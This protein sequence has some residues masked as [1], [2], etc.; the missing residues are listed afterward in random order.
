M[1]SFSSHFLIELRRYFE[2]WRQHNESVSF[3]V[4]NEQN[5][6]RSQNRIS[7]ESATRKAKVQFG[8]RTDP[9]T[10]RGKICMFELSANLIVLFDPIKFPRRSSSIGQT[11][12]FRVL[13]FAQK[14]NSVS[15]DRTMKQSG[16]AKKLSK[17]QTKDSNSTLNSEKFGGIRVEQ[18]TRR[19]LSLTV[20]SSN[21]AWS[22]DRK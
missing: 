8:P 11:A 10:R 5:C 7:S 1:E 16:S 18:R 2:K 21:D 22:R 15:A 13:R 20:T 14:P 19:P 17:L 3:S 4:C 12:I 9:P 6:L